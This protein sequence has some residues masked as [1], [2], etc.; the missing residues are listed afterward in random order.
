MKKVSEW[1]K[2][3]SEKEK[4]DFLKRMEEKK[5][6][7]FS[8]LDLSWDKAKIVKIGKVKMLIP[9]S[10]KLKDFYFFNKKDRVKYDRCNDGR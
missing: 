1:W 3:L 6:A 5:A 9:Y 10:N 8:D 2:N 4:W 7:A